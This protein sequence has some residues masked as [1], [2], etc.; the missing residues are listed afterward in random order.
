MNYKRLLYALIL[1]TNTILYA[2]TN[3]SIKRL[4]QELFSSPYKIDR[5]EHLIKVLISEQKYEEAEKYIHKALELFNQPISILNLQ[6]HL[7]TQQKKIEQ[8]AA[9]YLQIYK[10]IPHN[11]H[12]PY[13]IGWCLSLLRQHARAI[14]YYLKALDLDS[15][16]DYAHLGIAKAYIATGNYTRAW[17][18]FERRMANY[19]KYVERINV[20]HMSLNDIVGKRV[21]VR[22][23]WGLGDMM[24]FVR[25][26]KELKKHGA[27]Q[28]I[29]QAFKPLAPL[30]SMCD[31]IDTVVTDGQHIPPYDIQIPMMSLPLLFNTTLNTI[32]HDFPYL[33]ADPSLVQKWQTFFSKDTTIKVGLCWGAKKIF[34]E[35]HPYTRRSIPL[36]MFSLLAGIPDVTFY[37]LQKIDDVDQLNDLPQSFKV[38]ALGPDFD[39]THGR[40]MDTAAVMH[41]LDLIISVDTSVIH[42]AGN[43]DTT[44]VWALLPY[45]AAWWWL[46]DHTDTPW[47]NNMRFF[48]QPRPH[49]W[50]SAFMDVKKTL[51]KFVQEKLKRR[52]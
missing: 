3:T 39:E 40:F 13:N 7:Y 38:H 41:N 44:P 27:A 12:I 16:Y 52:S 17:P 45:N 4:E 22:A 43:L 36:T 15:E 9:L 24:Q 23:E 48:R 6:A 18:H 42:L 32:P 8:A 1:I 25:F 2:G 35:D 37:S 26:T 29:V 31:Y 51:E 47:Y 46:Y 19:K 28:V 21:L 20:A 10:R 33:Q 5:Y 49:D 30:F 50:H 34:L 11:K 14:P